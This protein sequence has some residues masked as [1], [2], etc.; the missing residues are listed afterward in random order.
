MVYPLITRRRILRSA[1]ALGLA[2]ADPLVVWGHILDAGSTGGGQ[3]EIA[4]ASPGS[5]MIVYSTEYVTREM[6]M[7][8]LNSWITPVE[9][10]FVRNNLLMPDVDLSSWQLSISGE[11][12]RPVRLSHSE[13]MQLAPA[14]VTNTIECAGNGRV[15]FRPPIGGVRWGRGAVGNARFEGP[16]LAEVLALARPKPTARHVAFRG[17]DV[18]PAGASEFVRSIPIAKARDP[19]TILATKM[20]GAKLTPEHGFPVRAL[21][22]GWIGSASIKWL[23]EIR[24][25]PHEYKGFYMDP[26][27]RVPLVAAGG[28]AGASQENRTVALT[29]LRVKSIIAHPAEGSELIL[30]TETPVA[31][32]GASWAGES[33]IA[34]VEVS[35]DDGQSWSAA[36]LGAEHAKYAWRLWRFDWKP[37]APGPY[38]IRSRATDSA[39]RVQPESTDWN[40]GGYLWNAEDAIRVQVRE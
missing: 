37:K 6:P 4:G 10:F 14:S 24:V 40:P 8:R 38:R 22:P 20:N 39:G 7:T 27:Y 29:G 2:V 28:A 35:T 34:K 25:L 18:V 3:G 19:Y 9:S 13:F 32:Q 36:E 12:E 11:V 5:G 21:V 31:V 1:T 15:N 17:L 30:S 23:C 16:R 26:G 33:S